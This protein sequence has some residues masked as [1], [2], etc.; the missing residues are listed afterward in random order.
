MNKYV[1][2]ALI[3]ASSSA[4]FA[5]TCQYPFD[6][7]SSQYAMGGISP[8]PGINYQ[9][10]EYPVQSTINSTGLFIQN[11]IAASNNGALAA[12]NSAG[13]GL[14][15]GDITLPSSG[16]IGVEIAI[17][18]FPDFST[19]NANL[20]ISMGFATSNHI[21]GA[22]LSQ[23]TADGLTFG[24][25]FNSM[26]SG[27]GIGNGPWAALLAYRRDGNQAGFSETGGMIPLQLP[28][29]ANYRAGLY[30][31]MSTR[32]M[33]FTLNG[34]DYGYAKDAAGNPFTVPASISSA[35]I[36]ASGVM[37]VS[38]GSDPL[39]GSPVGATLI[40]DRSQFNQPFPAGTT[41]IC[42]NTGSLVLPNG[43]PYPGK[44]IP[45]GLLPFQPLGMTHK[46]KKS[47]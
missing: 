35:M 46:A 15:G 27:T 28:L 29:P 3:A 33:G 21:S 25:M 30:L 38:S 1:A 34:V 32:Q 23:I 42:G 7:T 5:T 45:P 6:A 13:T 47:K 10:V 18:N 22:D 17:D 26:T 20:N 36:L 31:N 16:I 4:S 11:Y 37:Q 9:S 8:F 40:T 24:L 12:I 41:D 19:P 14:P 43:K 39:L 2:A 44:A